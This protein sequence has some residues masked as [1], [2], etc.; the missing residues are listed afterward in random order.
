MARGTASPNHID[1]AR[2][3]VPGVLVSSQS[4][5]TGKDRQRGTGVGAAGKEQ[6]EPTE[7]TGRLPGEPRAVASMI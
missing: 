2:R 6:G 7:R 1:S 5:G 4:S 3:W